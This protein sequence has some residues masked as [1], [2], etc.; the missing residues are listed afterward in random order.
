MTAHA[1]KVLVALGAK[2]VDLPIEQPQKAAEAFG[3]I[4]TN[5]SLR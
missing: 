1:Q 5:R 2:S 4:Q 3:I